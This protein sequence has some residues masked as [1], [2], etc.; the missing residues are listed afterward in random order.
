[1]SVA[2]GVVT[3]VD[4][5]VLVVSINR[6]D[7][8]NSV[9]RGV[10]EAIA[11]ALDRLDQDDSLRVGVLTGVGP[12]FSAGMDLKAFARGESPV[13]RR[14]WFRRNHHEERA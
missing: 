5:E 14:P 2:E 11:S 8:R 4:D 7:A 12:G 6:P 10:A 1:M 3:S 13:A 9:D